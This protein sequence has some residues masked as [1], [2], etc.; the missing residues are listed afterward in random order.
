MKK[1]VGLLTAGGDCQALN[2]GLRAITLSAIGKY[3][4][5]VIGFY[6]GYIGLEENQYIE[7]TTEKV[8]GIISWGGTIL[9]TG[10]GKSETKKTEAEAITACV[11][12]YQYLNL[13]ALFCLGGDGTQRFAKKL[14]DAGLKV[15]TLPKTIDNDINKTDVTFGFDTATQIATDAI[16]RLHTTT[17]SH[18]RCMIIEVM[19]RD[20]GWLA[21][22]SGLAGA[23]DIVIIPELPYDLEKIAQ[24]I[25]DRSF[26]HRHYSMIVVAE[27]AKWKENLEMKQHQAAMHLLKDLPTLTNVETRLVTLG[28]V[29]RGGTPTANDRILAT[30]LAIKAMDCF[31]QGQF[32][33][34]IAKQ[35]K[36]LL[37][38]PL[39]EVAGPPRLIPQDHFLLH[40]L[41]QVQI[42]LGG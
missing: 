29:M 38:V 34:M 10:R 39:E 32:G 37:A 6:D 3:D 35:G 4:L 24:A 17:S 40:S 15:I 27:G 14:M 19:G 36:E 20:A 28:H 25:S 7:L 11:D 26:K 12:A 18:H 33:V 22:S 16:D 21:A 42:C 5:E 9:G 41:R 2:A 1:R 23:A 8:S 13:Q 31:N 30:K